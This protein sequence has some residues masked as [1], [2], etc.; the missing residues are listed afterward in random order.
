MRLKRSTAGGPLGTGPKQDREA[1]VRLL[2]VQAGVKT[3]NLV[4]VRETKPN[5][6]ET[7]TSI[8]KSSCGKT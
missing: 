1:A 3:V 8:S 4:L 6:L 5:V 2:G 7:K